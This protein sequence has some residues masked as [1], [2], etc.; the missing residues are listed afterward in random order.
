MLVLWYTRAGVNPLSCFLFLCLLE[1]PFPEKI[2]LLWLGLATH[3]L[4]LARILMVIFAKCVIELP[5]P[6]SECQTD[7]MATILY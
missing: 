3:F 2:V 5:F 6:P 7:M 4:I 1:G